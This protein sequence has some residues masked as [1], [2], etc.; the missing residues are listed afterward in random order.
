MTRQ[1]SDARFWFIEGENDAIEMKK[2]QHPGNYDYMSGWRDAKHRLATGE[3][4]WRWN[5]QQ[6]FLPVE[7]DE[8]KIAVDD[9]RF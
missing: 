8:N 5:D 9:R 3:I 4:C 2:P 7:P 6:E 1:D